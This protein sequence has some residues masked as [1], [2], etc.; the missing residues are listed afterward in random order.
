M[1]VTDQ[2]GLTL[3][4]ANPLTEPLS[5]IVYGPMGSGKSTEIAMAFQNALALTSQPTVH[6][7][8]ASWIFAAV[9]DATIQPTPECPFPWTR[10]GIHLPPKIWVPEHDAARKVID[11]RPFFENVYTAVYA[12]LVKGACPYSAIIIDEMADF[13]I[14]VKTVTEA[15]PGKNKWRKMD[16]IKEWVR[17]VASWARSLGIPVIMI[18]HETPPKYDQEEGSVTFGK[19]L[20]QGGPNFPYAKLISEV[21]HMVD[22]CLRRV[23]EAAAMPNQPAKIRYITQNTPEYV[24]KF[25]DINPAF[26]EDKTLTELL[27]LAYYPV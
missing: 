18:M 16:K 19:M 17:S 24:A 7:T 27:K 21:G 26:C 11:P 8:L 13:M 12:G 20:S 3:H 4:A 9:D 1:N 23:L 2:L 6:R 10:Q 5:A 25:R 15:E 22:V 14:R